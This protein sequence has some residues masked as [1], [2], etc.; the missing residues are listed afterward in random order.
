MQQ[1]TQPYPRQQ[2]PLKVLD[3][4]VW[5]TVWT[6]QTSTNPSRPTKA[7]LPNGTIIELDHYGD[8]WERATGYDS[9]GNYVEFTNANY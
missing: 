5:W 8:N 1:S 9:Q 7:L 4:K 2:A 3:G 6:Y